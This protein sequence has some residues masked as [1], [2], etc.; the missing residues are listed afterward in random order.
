MDLVGVE[1]VVEEGEAGDFQLP[2]KYNKNDFSTL[3]SFWSLSPDINPTT[4]ISILTLDLLPPKPPAG[5]R[6]EG[7]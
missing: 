5:R 1:T 6:Q 4:P 7:H 2:F 3:I